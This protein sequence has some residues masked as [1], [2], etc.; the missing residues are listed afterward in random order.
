MDMFF[1]CNPYILVLLEDLY[2]WYVWGSSNKEKALQVYK[3]Q[4]QNL[5][6]MLERKIWEDDIYG[7]YIKIEELE[8]CK[9]LC[10]MKTPEEIWEIV[11]IN[12]LYTNINCSKIVKS[13]FENWLRCYA[14]SWLDPDER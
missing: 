8:F 13:V 9:I 1:C 7:R 4:C 2:V 12:D 14:D 3:K 10:Q 5:F 6:F 11:Q